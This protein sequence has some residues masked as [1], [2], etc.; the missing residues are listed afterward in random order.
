MPS[1]WPPFLQHECEHIMDGR[2]FDSLTQWWVNPS[3]R[4]TLRAAMALAL[5]G[6]LALGETRAA[7]TVCRQPGKTCK[8]ETQ[9][10]SGICKKNGKHHEKKCRPAF[11]QFTCTIAQDSCLQG[12]LNNHC[13]DPDK[14]CSCLVTAQGAS[15][16]GFIIEIADDCAFCAEQFPDTVCVQGG[17]Q[18][19]DK[20]FVCALPCDLVPV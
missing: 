20:P 13:S 16:C 12:D 15:F 1:E 14:I 10:C 7:S 8:R 11:S 17:I 3:R 6:P 5:A 4:T 9:C 18:C 19:L 2:N